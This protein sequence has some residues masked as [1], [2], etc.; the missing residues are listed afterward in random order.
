M[1]SK[2]VAFGLLLALLLGVAVSCAPSRKAYRTNNL[3][4]KSNVFVY[5]ADSVDVV[6]NLS[7]FV[8]PIPNTKFL[9]LFRLNLFTYEIGNMLRKDS[10]F[11]NFLQ[12]SWGEAPVY[13]D[14]AF[15]YKTISQFNQE[16]FNQGFFNPEISFKTFVNNKNNAKLY[17]EEARNCINN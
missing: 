5:D 14:T 13:A 7:S 11:K 3:L 12:K 15:F 1:K 16:L 17:I 6:P 2:N 4:V 10:K 8:V 9:G